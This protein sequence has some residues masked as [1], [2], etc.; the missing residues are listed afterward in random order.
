MRVKCVV[1]ERSAMTGCLLPQVLDADLNSKSALWLQGPG[2]IGLSLGALLSN[3]SIFF[4]EDRRRITVLDM[5]ANSTKKV[6]TNVLPSKFSQN[7]IE[8]I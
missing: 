4:I 3:S 7:R 2:S 1:N 8:C 5:K 6:A